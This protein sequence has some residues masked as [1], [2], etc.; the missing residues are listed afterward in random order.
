MRSTIAFLLFFLLSNFSIVEAKQINTSL[1]QVAQEVT[2]SIGSVEVHCN[3][4]EEDHCSDQDDCCQ[5]I[6]SC[7]GFPLYISPK[8]KILYSSIYK[9]NSITWYYFSGYQ[10]PSL[11]SGLKPPFHS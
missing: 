11:E 4:C 3:D 1:D 7:S 5:S 9:L 8:F 6:C 2:D 10:P